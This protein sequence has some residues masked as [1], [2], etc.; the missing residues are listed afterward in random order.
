MNVFVDLFCARVHTHAVTSTNHRT[1]RQGETQ[2][3]L[4]IPTPVYSAPFVLP[5]SDLEHIEIRFPRDA[6]DEPRFARI[7]QAYQN[8]VA[9]PPV[10]LERYRGRWGLLDGNHRLWIARRKGIQ[11]I[12]CVEVVNVADIVAAYPARWRVGS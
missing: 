8:G 10:T 11:T 12:Q 7:E 1:T 3:G 9:L 5:V 6:T 4:R 2:R